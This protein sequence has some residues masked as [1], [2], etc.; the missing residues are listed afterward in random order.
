[1][2]I[3]R[4]LVV[5]GKG[6]GLRDYSQQ[7]ERGVPGFISTALAQDYYAI[8]G[9][10]FIVPTP[11]FAAGYQFA[12]EF[13][14]EDG[15]IDFVAS[16]ITLHIHIIT[17]SLRTNDLLLCELRKYTEAGALVERFGSRWNYGKAELR[18]TAG[19]PCAEG[20]VWYIFFGAWPQTPTYEISVDLF[21]MVSNLTLPWI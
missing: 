8:T 13:P 5:P 15:S 1:M 10:T 17:A 6:V 3:E 7:I 20:F 9:A 14:Q 11:A 12:L 2:G 4:T 16:S 21:G 18:F 19:M